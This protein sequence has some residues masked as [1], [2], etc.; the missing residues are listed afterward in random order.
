MTSTR[1]VRVAIT[2]TRNAHPEMPADLAQLEGKLEAVRAANVAH[3]V[4]LMRAAKAQGAAIIGFGEL[5]TGPYFAL[6]KDPVWF[7][8]AEDAARGP[9][10]TELSAAAKELSMIVVAPIYE[11]DPSGQ[12]FNTAVV[13][14]EQGEILGK[15]RKT[16]LPCGANEQGSFDE[17]F[18]YDR[19]DG[20]N[21]SGP[22]NVSKNP[23][24]PVF[25]TSVGRVGVAICYDRHFEGVMSS[26]AHEGAELVFSPAVTFGQKSQRMW[27]LEFQVDAARHNLFIAGSNR[28]GSEPPWTQPYFGESYVTGPSGVLPNLSEHPDLVVADVDLAVL[29]RPDPS[30][31]NLPRDVRHEIYSKRG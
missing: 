19:S 12:R 8:L 7:G 27:Q 2:E 6:G 23:F 15:Y 4:E 20:K 30:G 22:A 21:G 26:L 1:V 29:S 14:D 13:I 25:Q 9:T 3:H 18:Y 10:V 5:F 28:R 31:W 11:L 17:P 24:F 16:H